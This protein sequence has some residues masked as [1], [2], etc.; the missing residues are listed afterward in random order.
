LWLFAGA[1]LAAVA[2]IALIILLTIRKGRT[3][4]TSSPNPS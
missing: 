3:T 1:F 4:P 2:V